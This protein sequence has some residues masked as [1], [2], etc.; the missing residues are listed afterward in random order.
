M[1]FR[2]ALGAL[3]VV[4]LSAVAVGLGVGAGIA[5]AAPGK[6]VYTCSGG[7]DR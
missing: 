3:I 6:T 2:V 5:S 1:R 4:A 7:T